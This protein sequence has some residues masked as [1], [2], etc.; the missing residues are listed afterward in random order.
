[1][2]NHHGNQNHQNRH[3]QQNDGEQRRR[4][5]LVFNRHADY[6]VGNMLILREFRPEKNIRPDFRVLLLRTQAQAVETVGPDGTPI[7][8]M[9]EVS[10]YTGR[11]DRDSIRIEDLDVDALVKALN[12]IKEAHRA[13]VE[14]YDTRKHKR[15]PYY[16]PRPAPP[17]PTEHIHVSETYVQQDV[18][19]AARIRIPERVRQQVQRAE[20]ARHEKAQQ[21]TD[22]AVTPPVATP[23]SNAMPLRLPA[24]F[25]EKIWQDLA[26]RG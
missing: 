6:S 8:A 19:I 17:E 21:H 3:Q 24:N 26:T 16:K 23:S 14:L 15:D 2:S 7:H 12:H 9:E 18:R 5:P 25:F 4:P 11:A 10:V 20:T 13:S 1:M 22:A